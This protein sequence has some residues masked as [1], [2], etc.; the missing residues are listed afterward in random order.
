MT[1]SS[2]GPADHQHLPT[3]RELRAAER[4][5]EQAA[6]EAE[7][8]AKQQFIA[9][10]E[11]QRRAEPT[12]PYGADDFGF[13]DG[14]DP[15]AH[16]AADKSSA[17]Y[18]AGPTEGVFENAPATPAP[19]E[20][21]KPAPVTQTTVNYIAIGAIFVGAVATAVTFLPGADIAALPLA[22]LALILAFVGL[23]KRRGRATVPAIA[24]IIALGAGGWAG[25]H[26]FQPT[27]PAS[28]DVSTV[29]VTSTGSKVTISNVRF[30]T[31]ATA[32]G[33]VQAP[34]STT[35]TGDA[36][37]TAAPVE[38]TDTLTCTISTA[39]T[40]PVRQQGQP[41]QPVHCTAQPT[42]KD[43]P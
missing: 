37:V 16:P 11:A 33:E 22:A 1:L 40:A 28:T 27:S 4:I 5:R 17:F 24:L 26:Q 34:Y 23:V 39:D 38:A 42:S 31:T 18:A 14:T 15:W 41:G 35:G 10:Y 9:D 3:R 21:D 7:E 6:H 32:P 12:E 8:A 30:G 13:G 25:W 2:D 20:P 36:A 43:T 29:S 19:A